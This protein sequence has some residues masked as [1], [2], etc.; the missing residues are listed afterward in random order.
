VHQ[1]RNYSKRWKPKEDNGI[2]VTKEMS[3]AL[4]ESVLSHC[5]IPTELRQFFLEY[6]SN[7]YLIDKKL[8]KKHFS[9]YNSN[10]E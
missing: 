7:T 2:L 8:Y 1:Q 3:S 9:M 6:L 4:A 5:T 10:Y